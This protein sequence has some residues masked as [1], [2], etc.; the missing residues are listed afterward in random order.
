M[1]MDFS[2]EQAN[3]DSPQAQPS[4]G[5]TFHITGTHSDLIS[6]GADLANHGYL[7]CMVPATA[8][9]ALN[10]VVLDNRAEREVRRLYKQWRATHLIL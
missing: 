6:L 1:R 2:R 10:I 7:G 3:T 5:G 4:E 9:M 8:G